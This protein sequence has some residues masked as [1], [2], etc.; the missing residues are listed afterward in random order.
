MPWGDSCACT[1]LSRSPICVGVICVGG[2]ADERCG[3]RGRSVISEK[4]VKHELG[5]VG[6]S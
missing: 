2:S 6:L 3:A 5:G 4:A 1:A